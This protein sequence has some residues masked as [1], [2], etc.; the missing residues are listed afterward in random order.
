MVLA[1]PFLLCRGLV[2]IQ[3]GVC[4][5][6]CGPRTPVPTVSQCG[7]ETLHSAISSDWGFLILSSV[8]CSILIIAQKWF[9]NLVNKTCMPPGTSCLTLCHFIPVPV[10][11]H[12][13]L[14]RNILWQVYAPRTLLPQHNA[15]PQSMPSKF[16]IPKTLL[17]AWGLAST[18][19]SEAWLRDCRRA[20][21][22]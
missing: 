5:S 7:P 19:C 12:N 10:C 9:Q 14:P 17:L 15:V 3:E 22:A 16:S 4:L 11:R 18:S 8:F 13:T 21:G 1:L 6:T 2:F 20:L